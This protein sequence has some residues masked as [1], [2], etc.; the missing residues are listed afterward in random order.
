MINLCFNNSRLWQSTTQSITNKIQIQLNIILSNTTTF[1][2]IQ[3]VFIVVKINITIDYS[4]AI[5]C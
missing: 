4:G 2:R 5:N 1:C 3:V